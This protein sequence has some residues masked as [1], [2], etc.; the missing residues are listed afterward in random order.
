MGFTL[1]HWC[2]WQS[3][4]G[5]H[6]HPWSGGVV[7]PCHD[8]TADVSFLPMMQ[9]RRLSPLARAAS[10][11]AWHCRQTCGD[12]A[13]VFYS[14]H[15]ESLYYF[16]MLQGLAAGEELSPSRFSLSVHNAIAG[17]SSFHSQSYLPYVSLAGGTEGV[18]A[19]FLEADGLI[20]ISPKVMLVCYEQVLP[21]AYRP[22]HASPDITWAFAMVLSRSAD[23]GQQLRFLRRPNPWQD[24]VDDAGY[25]LLQSM[26]QGVRSSVCVT[27]HAL[28]QWSLDD[29]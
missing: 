21:E 24:E 2:L 11:V 5:L 23:H 18:F 6:P 29:A 3:Q 20:R 10:A 27:G 12:M 15:G 8:G 19:A 17:L 26:L 14:N 4:A 28:W 9:S 13:S 16:E 25:G 1:Q 7:L 22:Y